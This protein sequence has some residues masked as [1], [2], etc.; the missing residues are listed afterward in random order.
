MDPT[1]NT[2]SCPN[3]LVVEDDEEIRNLI[4]LALEL[5]GYKVFTAEN[6][7]IGLDV[8]RQIPRPCL[9]LLDLMMPIM[10]GWAFV[11]GLEKD[12]KLATIPVVVVSAFTEV[13]KP[14]ASKGFIKKPVDLDKLF[15]IVRNWCPAGHGKGASEKI[16]AK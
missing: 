3:V 16:D 11:E 12:M 10:N 8:L 2:S 13:E 4:K 6:G 9:I 15:E 14:I 5:E 1:K 7:Q